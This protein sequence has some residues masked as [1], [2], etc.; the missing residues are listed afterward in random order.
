M[1]IKKHIK[2]NLWRLYFILDLLSL[3]LFQNEKKT[4][5]KPFYPNLTLEHNF[6]EPKQVN[7]TFVNMTASSLSFLSAAQKSGFQWMPST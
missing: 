4:Q 5:L 3:G 7:L 6:S 1:G 2:N